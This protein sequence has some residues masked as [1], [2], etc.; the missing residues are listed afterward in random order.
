MVSPKNL[1]RFNDVAKDA[2]PKKGDIVFI[3]R[4]RKRWEGNSLLHTVRQNETLYS[5]SQS[6]GI[7]LKSLAKLNGVRTDCKLN[8]GQ[9]IKIR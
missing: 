9:S 6:Y 8:N 1:R 4:K 3:E 2:Q 5:L 7:R